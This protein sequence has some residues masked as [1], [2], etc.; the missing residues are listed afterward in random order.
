MKGPLVQTIV[1]VTRA[2]VVQSRQPVLFAAIPQRLRA[3]GAAVLRWFVVLCLFA[4]LLSH[5]RLAASGTA[6]RDLNAVQLSYHIGPLDRGRELVTR[7][8]TDVNRRASQHRDN[9]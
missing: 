7:F 9:Q 6:N 8:N 2:C 5:A 1:Q 3:D 4:A